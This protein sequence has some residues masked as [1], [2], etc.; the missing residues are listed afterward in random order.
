MACLK[1][2][3]LEVCPVPEASSCLFLTNTIV[4]DLVCLQIFEANRRSSI[5]SLLGA[6]SVAVLKCSFASVMLSRS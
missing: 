5:S 2:S 3:T 6:I 1:A 4:F